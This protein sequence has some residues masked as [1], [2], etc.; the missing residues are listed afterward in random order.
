MR[1]RRLHTSVDFGSLSLDGC[2]VAIWTRLGEPLGLVELAEQAPC[3]FVEAM[4]RVR[5]LV[6]LGLVELLIDDD[7]QEA[8]LERE[9]RPRRPRPTLAFEGDAEPGTGIHLKP[10]PDRNTRARTLLGACVVGRLKRRERYIERPTDPR[11]LA[12]QFPR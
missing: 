12:K 5:R 10:L 11:A 6:E 7:W 1:A 8:S 4:E 9:F 3:A 2:D